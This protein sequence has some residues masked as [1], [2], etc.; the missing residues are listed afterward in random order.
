MRDGVKRGRNRI[1][2]D[3]VEFAHLGIGEMLEVKLLQRVADDLGDQHG[4]G[5]GFRRKRSQIVR[6]LG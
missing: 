2:Y 5:M 3:R 4:D 1:A 6:R